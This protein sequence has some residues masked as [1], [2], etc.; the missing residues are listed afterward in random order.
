MHEHTYHLVMD[1]GGTKV[2]AIL[3]DEQFRL[4]SAHRVGSFRQFA[5]ADDLIDQHMEQ[6]FGELQLHG[7]TLHRISGM[8]D[9]RFNEKLGRVC[10]IEKVVPHNE[11]ELCLYAAEIFGDGALALAGTG[12]HARLQIGDTSYGYGG[13]G[14][15]ISDEGGGYWIGREALNAAIL[16][17]QRRGPATVLTDKILAAV[18]KDG[19]TLDTALFRFYQDKNRSP[20]SRIA[21]CCRLVSQAADEGDAVALDILRRAGRGLAEQTVAALKKYRPAGD[22]PLTVGGSVWKANAAFARSFMETLHTAYPEK[23]LIL[24]RFEPIVGSI[25]KHYYDENGP[26]TDEVR[27]RFEEEFSR[28]RFTVSPETLSV[29]CIIQP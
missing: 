20:S 11:F 25:L 26:L 13:Y 5:T 10:K 6:L 1:F 8:V 4:I 16:Q 18:G 9:R 7:K 12:S 28:F 22:L 21:D 24:P 19:D 3:Y 2:A 29:P 14:A 15:L 23:P 17:D 27:R